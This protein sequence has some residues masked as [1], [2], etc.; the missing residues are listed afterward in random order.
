MEA[1]E[2]NNRQLSSTGAT[3]SPFYINEGDLAIL[4]QLYSDFGG[5]SWNGTKWNTS[6]ELVANGNWSGITFDT[7][8]Y[9]TSINLQKRALTGSLSVTTP[10]I[11]SLSRLTSLNLSRNTLTGDPALYLSGIGSQ[12]TSVDL[13]YNQIDE[14][15]SVL[16]STITT[17]N[18]GYQYRKDGNV[19]SFP[20]FDEEQPVM[21]NV[22]T[23]MTPP[24][25][26]LLSYNHAEQN[27]S[28]HPEITI[29]KHSTSGLNTVYG[30]LRWSATNDCYVFSLYATVNA[31][32][33]ELVHMRIK[34]GAMAESSYPATIHFIRGDA[35]STGFVD[36]TDVQSTLNYILTSSSSG[37]I[38]LWAANTWTDDETEGLINIQDIVCT[39]NLVLD[40]QGEG[41][42]SYSL[43][44]APA[45][46]EAAANLFY[47]SGRYVELKAQDEIAAFCLEL[48]GVKSDQIR[49]LLNLND[50]QMQTRDTDDGVRLLV[51]SPTGKTLPAGQSRLLRMSSSGEPVGV[52]ASNVAAQTV[53]ASVLN[54]GATD[55][56]EL[57]SEGTP[58]DTYDL[59]GRKMNDG[60]LQKGI[61]VK[62]GRKEVRK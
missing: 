7:E 12:L 33:D 52:Q 51:F 28:T 5:D 46:N 56:E 45:L 18:L 35:N 23:N 57:S 20:G 13:S 1:D 62:K 26:T 2:T 55:I 43:R 32:Q 38:C 22:G 39:V 16:A 30:Y 31:A 53:D 17:L 50:W 37:G 8:G 9:V 15:S 59:Q 24:M 27:F 60:K 49:L 44:R 42:P 4:R 36:V 58:T 34:S 14:L 54:D 21:L 3:L 19:R 29:Y 47:A 10:Y 25:P 48:Q 40:N 11:A 6:S 61:Y 41:S